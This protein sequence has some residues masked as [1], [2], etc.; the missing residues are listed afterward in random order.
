MIMFGDP[1]NPLSYIV[2][3]LLIL[4]SAFFAGSETA[5]ASCNRHRM[6]VLAEDGN[7][8]AKLVLKI[9]DKFD[10]TIIVNLIVVNICHVLTS[11][12]ATLLM[13]K[14]LGE[15]TGSIVATIVTTLVVYMF[16]DL[17][18][19]NI[20]NAN[21]DKWAL[22]TGFILYFFKI[23]LYPIGMLFQLLL[24]G[25]KKVF[26][27][28]EDEDTFDEEDFQ[29]VIE[30][31]EEE[32][33]LDEEESDI[34]QAAIEFGDKKV[35][36]VL[37]PRNKI[38]GINIK[39]C[40]QEYLKKI[41]LNNNYSRFPVYKNNIDN[42][43]GVLHVRSYLKEIFL[44]DK[45]DINDVLIKPYFVSPSAAIDEIFAGFSEHKT[46]LAIVT[47]KGVTIGMVT[48]KDVLEEL[49]TDIDDCDTVTP[50]KG[51][52]HA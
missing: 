39:N 1:D 42:I 8:R 37:T 41:I 27:L 10:F 44:N 40:N 3:I 21:S 51:D 11:V 25:T 33:I 43:I 24:F 12:I 9:L 13:V 4:T 22:N 48:M 2:I 36:E 49:I 32:G 18:P 7:K 38:V 50:V 31:V 14:L 30:K 17:I 34:I 45:V 15:A 16:G 26:S 29:D 5:Y 20:A 19:K 23:I 46:H 52:K 35:K 28:E 6:I 47:N